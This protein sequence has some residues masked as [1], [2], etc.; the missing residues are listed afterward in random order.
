MN[1]LIPVEFHQ[2][3]TSNEA[4]EAVEAQGAVAIH[5]FL[6][7]DLRLEALRELRQEAMYTDYLDESNGVRR[8]QNL[9]CFGFAHN[10]SWL[11]EMPVMNRPSKYVHDSAQII[12]DFINEADGVHWQPNEII[13]HEY[14]TGQFL[15]AHRDYKRA[16]GFVAVATLDGMQ[17]FNVELDSGETK[18]IYMKPG[19][20]TIM[21]GYQGE[22]GKQRPLHSVEPAR[23][24]R[25]AFSLRQMSKLPMW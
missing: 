13:G 14:K 2:P 5:N 9:S 25:L 22:A 20:V 19:T 12:A 3:V 18:Q 10:K 1:T 17:N 7:N 11:T 15:D 4:L 21:R 23:C 6:P 16:I 8:N 24:R